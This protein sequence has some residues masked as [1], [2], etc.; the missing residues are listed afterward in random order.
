MAEFNVLLQGDLAKF[1][2]R[3]YKEPAY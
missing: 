1:D 3:A 2:C